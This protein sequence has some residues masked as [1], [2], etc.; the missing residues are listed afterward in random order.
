MP[1]GALHG[2]Y[3]DTLAG[4]VIA[5]VLLALVAPIR[6]IKRNL[7]TTWNALHLLVAHQLSVGADA[8][9]LNCRQQDTIPIGNSHNHTTMPWERGW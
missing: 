9:R 7:V 4:M 5:D 6:F 3:H 8:Q 2:V 1:L